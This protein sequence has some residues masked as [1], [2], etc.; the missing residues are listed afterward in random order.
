L[1][2][3]IALH[4]RP[5]MFAQKA[6]PHYE[7]TGKPKNFATEPGKV[8]LCPGTGTKFILRSLITTA[9]KQGWNIIETLMKTADQ[10]IPDL[11]Y[12]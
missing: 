9:R 7:Q 1:K 12:A 4:P 11:K 6:L 2:S 3:I 10:L 8:T 5:V